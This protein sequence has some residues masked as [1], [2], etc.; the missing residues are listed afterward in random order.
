MTFAEKV[1]QVLT[2]L[3]TPY[4]WVDHP[5]VYTVEEAMRHLP[6]KTPVKNLLLQEKG[7]GRKILVVMAGNERLDIKIVAK[8][9]GTRKLQFADA[10]VLKQTLGVEPGSVSLFS[11]LYDGAA[12]V[13]VAMDNALLQSEELGFHP[14]I[15]TATIFIPGNSIRK[16]VTAT[17]HSCRVMVL[18]GHA[19]G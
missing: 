12:G 7:G 10:G 1:K 8:E 19:D 6:D 18:S 5:P 17:G 15:N 14:N 13:D 9:F 11:L 4:R 3:G 16:F 2:E